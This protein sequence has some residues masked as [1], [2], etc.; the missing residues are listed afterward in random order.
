MTRT[1][2]KNLALCAIFVPLLVAG[3]YLKIPIPIIPFTLQTFF[4]LMTGLLLG[5]KL[6]LVSTIAYVAL[7][8]MGLPFFTGG[9]G[10]AY[11]LHPTFGYLIGFIVGASVIGAIAYAEPKRNR[12]DAIDAAKSNSMKKAP[13]YRRLL[14]ANLI[15][16]LI[17]YALGVPYFYLISRFYL[18]N[19]IG[20]WTLFVSCFLTTAP[21][22]IALALLAALIAKRLIPILGTQKKNKRNSKTET[23]E[24]N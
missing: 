1:R 5:P 20:I 9:G 10:F 19:P 14:V 15:G 8:L 17:I 16:L 18:N 13:S 23:E 6:S 7:G 4:V 24:Q 12:L 11:V 21:S 2:T 3:A 22:D